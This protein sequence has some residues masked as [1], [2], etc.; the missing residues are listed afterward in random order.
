MQ[1]NLQC[2][3]YRR[4]VGI[5]GKGTVELIELILEWK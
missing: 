1:N 2:E 5:E 4:K 3:F